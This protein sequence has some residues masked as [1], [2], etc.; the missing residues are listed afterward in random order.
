MVDLKVVCGFWSPL[1]G[2]VV[3]P[4]FMKRPKDSEDDDTQR[5]IMDTYF[6]G[7]KL[8]VVIVFDPNK[9]ESDVEGQSTFDDFGAFA[10]KA[11]GS[12]RFYRTFRRRREVRL[13]LDRVN[14]LSSLRSVIHRAAMLTVTLAKKA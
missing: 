4:I 2:S 1:A 7:E 13:V 12:A 10:V 11:F 5:I 3:L 9:N 6:T 14:D 8:D